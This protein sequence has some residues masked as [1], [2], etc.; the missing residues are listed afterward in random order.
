MSIPVSSVCC[1]CDILYG[2]DIT[3][4]IQSVQAVSAILLVIAILLVRSE[5][6]V[7]GSFGGGDVSESDAP[8]RRG[9]EKIMFIGT[10]V[11]AC[12]FVGSIILPLV[13]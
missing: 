12:I 3:M 8:T 2:M 13:I 9:S 6:S 7:G 10:I 1:V 5:A 4:I 11:L